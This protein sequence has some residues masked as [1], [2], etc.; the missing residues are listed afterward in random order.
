MNEKKFQSSFNQKEKNATTKEKL[1]K[2]GTESLLTGKLLQSRV[3]TTP[4][5]LFEDIYREKL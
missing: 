3:T 5:S 1:K 4:I 2:Y